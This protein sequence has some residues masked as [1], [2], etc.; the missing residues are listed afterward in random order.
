MYN[1][2]NDYNDNNLRIHERTRFSVGRHFT[3]VLQIAP[4]IVYSNDRF[5]YH[6]KCLARIE[7]FLRC[8]DSSSLTVECTYKVQ[9][10]AASKTNNINGQIKSLGFQ[11]LADW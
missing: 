3:N 2:N 7:M 10:R 9:E 1:Y 4:Y 8:I 6:R 11:P 5:R